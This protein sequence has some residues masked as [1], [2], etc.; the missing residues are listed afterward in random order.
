MKTQI[1]DKLRGREG[2][3]KKRKRE[4]EMK[5]GEERDESTDVSD[6][7]ALRFSSWPPTDWFWMWQLLLHSLMQMPILFL[8]LN[9]CFNPPKVLKFRI[10]NMLINP[11]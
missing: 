10:T 2:E 3:G 6:S 1:Q 4:T 7:S 11:I 5:R 8:L 9:K